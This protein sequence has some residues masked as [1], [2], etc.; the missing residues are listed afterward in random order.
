VNVSDDVRFRD[1]ILVGRLDKTAYGR[2]LTNLGFG[3]QLEQTFAER[4]VNKD[5]FVTREEYATPVQ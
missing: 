3:A 1:L 5:G 4:E 2:L